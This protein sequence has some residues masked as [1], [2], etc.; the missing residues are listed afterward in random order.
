MY[1]KKITRLRDALSDAGLD[2]VVKVGN[3]FEELRVFPSAEEQEQARFCDEQVDKGEEGMSNQRRTE[4]E[5]K[6]EEM[7]ADVD[8]L[9]T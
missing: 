4:K 8:E 9:L 1:Q 3:L 5:E 7:G 6:E 2:E